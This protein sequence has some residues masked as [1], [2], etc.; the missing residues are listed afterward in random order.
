[1]YADID[2]RQYEPDACRTAAITGE[3]CFSAA[4][5]G[6]YQVSELELA[7]VCRAS[8]KEPGT[9]MAVMPWPTGAAEF[10]GR[11]SLDSV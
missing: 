8:P 6:T 9:W 1:M 5:Q 11:A 3:S 4:S 2:R 7:P 10:S